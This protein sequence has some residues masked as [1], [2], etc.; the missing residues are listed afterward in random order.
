MGQKILKII[1]N[2]QKMLKKIQKKV[3][4]GSSRVRTG[5]LEIMDPAC[6]QKATEICCYK[7]GFLMLLC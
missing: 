7:I 5:D 2:Y 1:K 3:F 4:L 6:Y